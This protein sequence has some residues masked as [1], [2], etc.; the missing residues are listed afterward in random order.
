MKA[1]WLDALVLISMYIF[2]LE[3]TLAIYQITIHY[4]GPIGR[5]LAQ[6]GNPFLTIHKTAAV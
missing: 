1:T 4:E 5:K 3:D 6:E 2:R